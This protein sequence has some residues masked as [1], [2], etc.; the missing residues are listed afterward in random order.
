[1]HVGLGLR[2]ENA[3]ALLATDAPVCTLLEVHSENYLHAGGQAAALLR[4]AGERHALSLHGV[5]LSLGSERTLDS[6]HLGGLVELVDR[7]QPALVSEHLCWNAAPDGRHYA[8]LLPLPRDSTTAGLLID[9]IQHVQERLRR[10]LLVEHLAAYAG[11][12]GDALE[13]PEWLNWIA[14]RSGCRLLIDLHNLHTSAHNLGFD[15]LRWLDHVAP[16]HVGQYHLAGGQWREGPC[17]RLRL[18]THDAL[19][20]DT[21]WSLYRHA[22]ARFGAH[23]TILEW[24][25]DLPSIAVQLAAVS[26]ANDLLILASRC[27][28]AL[29]PL[30]AAAPEPIAAA[31]VIPAQ[32]QAA[33]SQRSPVL[34][35]LGAAQTAWAEALDGGAAAEPPRTLAAPTAER[36]ARFA[37]YRRNHQHH[38]LAALAAIYPRLGRCVGADCLRMLCWAYVRKHPLHTGNLLEYGGAMPALVAA[39]PELAEWPWLPDLA[40]LEWHWHRVDRAP[41]SRHV[42]SLAALAQLSE[43]QL[44]ALRLRPIAASAWLSSAWDLVALWTQLGEAEDAAPEQIAAAD[45]QVL[46]ARPGL[47]PLLR[48]LP[49][50]AAIWWSAIASGSSLGAAVAVA[51]AA[52]PAFD[53]A[54]T[55]ALL[56][57]SGVLEQC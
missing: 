33:T 4:A 49:P 34:A 55:L 28:P 7:V 46:V 14:A 48:A 23:P 38:L 6:D 15:P 16:Q 36:T 9:R 18:D 40:R 42:L 2:A 8:D 51:R 45:V 50:G 39:R 24:D 29:P 11:C 37:I 12:T 21:V 1:M 53:L 54:A 30:A 43:T 5:G 19:P 22:L 10:P 32:T 17:G 52:Q 3:A 20:D 57:P 31:C 35:A 27:T 44:D 56:V 13:E 41:D 25:A 26:Q 47:S